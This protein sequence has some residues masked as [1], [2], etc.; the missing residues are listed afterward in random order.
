[1]ALGESG[2]YLLG[3]FMGDALAE[4][5]DERADLDFFPFPEINP[6]FGQESV[7]APIDGFMIS[8]EPKNIDAAKALMAYLGTGEAQDNY[9]KVNPN[10]LATANEADTTIYTPLQD[11]ALELIGSAK[12]IAQFL[13]RDTDPGFASEVVGVAL[14]SF[15]SDPG[16]I[17][18]ILADVEA[19]KAG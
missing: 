13:D 3:L 9:T 14:A 10:W 15:I 19:Q 4:L 17:D 2:M 6:D 1:M 18:N 12:N 11:K 8:K 7:E 16:D 5:P